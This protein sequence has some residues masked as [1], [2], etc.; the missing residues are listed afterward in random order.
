MASRKFHVFVRQHQ[1]DT[2][3]VSALTLPSYATHAPTLDEALDELRSVLAGELALGVIGP[4]VET[5]LEGVER[6]I[7]HVTLRAV[8]HERL[9]ELP[10]RV[11]ALYRERD[12]RFDVWL[13]RLGQRFSIRDRAAIDPW[14]EEVIRG[15]FHLADIDDAR[16]YEHDRGERVDE[17]LVGSRKIDGK[18]LERARGSQLDETTSAPRET[19]EPGK[20]ESVLGGIGRDLVVAAELGTIGHAYLRDDDCERLER[21][22]LTGQSAL[23]VGPS[24]VGKTAIVHELAHRMH[25]E[26]TAFRRPLWHVT[27]G[28]LMARTPFL[29]MWQKRV[30]EVLGAARNAGAILYLGELVALVRATQEA[31]GTGMSLPRLI[32]PF[33]AQREVQVLLESTPDGLSASESTDPGLPAKLRRIAIP[34]LEPAQVFDVVGRIARGHASTH[35]VAIQD[36][37]LVRALDLIARFGDV[38]GLPG[39]ALPVVERMV[40]RAAGRESPVAAREATDAFCEHTGYPRA[41]VDP[42]HVLSMEE[43]ERHFTSRVH[44]QPEATSRLA[45]VVALLKAGLDDPHRPVASFLFMGPTGVGKT[46]SALTLAE[47]LFGHR[48]RVVRLDMSEYG[49][50]GAAIRLI[51]GRY[52][53]G[54]LTRPIR[55]QPFSVVL[56]D[57]IE[58]AATEVF[59]LLLQVL[60][61]GRL[62]DAT[63]R[64]ASFRHAIV[65]MTS[66]LGA[67]ARAPI[68]LHGRDGG[69]A[70][71][72]YL[73]AAR[74]FFRPELLNRIDHVVPFGALDRESLRAIARRLLDQALEREGLARRGLR[75]RYD[76]ALLG[77]IAEVGFDPTLGA[78]PMK[79]AIDSLVLVQLAERIARGEAEGATG[80]LL[81]LRDGAVAVDFER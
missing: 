37:A 46:E 52:G 11:T 35:H 4:G 6:R 14:A 72:D 44:G 24:G 58:K 47:Y 25:T 22:L 78:R 12:G 49:H 68:G 69:R 76:D 40:R 54:D 15:R 80:L 30:L 42:D 64:T 53:E 55:Q 29:G 62:T 9:I 71:P 3:T 61:E 2:F 27:A 56:L 38:E 75:A 66:N 13:P 19:E 77:H 48:E 26:R 28:H 45:N 43:V 39:S 18:R 59:D 34:S 16:A 1:N 79:R 10:L 32:E 74:R 60:G 8:Q 65:I 73:G 33:V 67:T 20:D 17:L 57:E 31:S 36:A 70:G 7:V 21:V 23:L 5:Y 50:F 81:S 51:E 41:L 63:G